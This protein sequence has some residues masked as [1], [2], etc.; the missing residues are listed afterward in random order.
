MERNAKGDLKVRGR[1]QEIARTYVSFPRYHATAAV[2]LPISGNS[3]FLS[4]CF[5]CDLTSSSFF[6]GEWGGILGTEGG[7]S[8]AFSIIS[9]C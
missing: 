6:F 4:L 5:V 2:D 8:C 1:K 3:D 7:K 9:F